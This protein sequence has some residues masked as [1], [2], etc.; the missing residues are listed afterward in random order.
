MRGV[1]PARPGHEL[2]RASAGWT[3]SRNDPTRSV[4]RGDDSPVDGQALLATAAA[5]QEECVAFKWQQGDV[6]IIDNALILHSRRPFEGPR[7]I[8]ASIAFA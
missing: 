4:L 2:G 8:L 5:M 1:Q 6:L 7:R 3:D